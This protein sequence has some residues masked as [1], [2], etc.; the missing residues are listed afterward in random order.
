MLVRREAQRLERRA[1]RAP[2]AIDERK[3]LGLDLVLAREA[4]ALAVES[5]AAELSR[6]AQLAVEHRVELLDELGF[7]QQRAQL[8]RGALPLDAAN[9]RGP[10]CGRDEVLQH[11]RAHRPALADVQGFWALFVEKVDARGVGDLVDHRAV[12]V[13][14]ERRPSRDLPR[15]NREDLLAMLRSRRAQE[16]PDRGGVG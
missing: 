2:Q 15:R 6:R 13:R 4:Q 10:G 14:R 7:A 5:E 16:L 9:A 8:A 12:E 3:R 1:P 11:A